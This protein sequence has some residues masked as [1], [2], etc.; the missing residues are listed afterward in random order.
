M[1]QTRERGGGKKENLLSK[2]RAFN[3]KKSIWKEVK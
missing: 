1:K 3:T 2:V